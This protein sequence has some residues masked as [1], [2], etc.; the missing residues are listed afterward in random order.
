MKGDERDKCNRKVCNNKATMFNNS[1]KKWYCAS[2]ASDIQVFENGMRDPACVFKEFY[3]GG[4][5]KR[6]EE[7]KKD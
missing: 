7:R 2:C 6:N 5:L 1:T 4:F 3:R